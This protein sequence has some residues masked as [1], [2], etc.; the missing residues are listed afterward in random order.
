MH[1][2]VVAIGIVLV[3]VGVSVFFYVM[4]STSGRIEDLG[5]TAGGTQ[6]PALMSDLSRLWGLVAGLC[7]AAGLALVGIG[8]NRWRQ[9]GA[10]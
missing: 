8:M 1:R 7:F 4:G 5:A 10:S 9:R 2:P 3:I 6:S